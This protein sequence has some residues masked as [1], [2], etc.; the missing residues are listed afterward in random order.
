MSLNRP[1]SEYSEKDTATFLVK[2]VLIGQ[3]SISAVVTD[4]NGRTISSAPLQIEVELL[5][6]LTS[7]LHCSF[8][9]KLIVNALRFIDLSLGFPTFQAAPEKS[10]ADYRGWDAG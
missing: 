1:L 3:T 5:T 7:S 8:I 10:H 9:L 6:A 2:G 4:K